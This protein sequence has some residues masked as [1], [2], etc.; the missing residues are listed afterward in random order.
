ML[1]V[2]RPPVPVVADDG[3][4]RLTA[5]GDGYYRLV[6]AF[7]YMEEPRLPPVLNQA[8]RSAGIPLDSTD[9]TFYAGYETIVVENETNINRIPEAIFSYLNRN[10]LHD[11][12]HYGVPIDQ[13]VEIGSQIRV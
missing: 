9:T 12:Q 4:W 10:A 13:V 7:G 11:E 1:T 5:L 3:R 8:A 2:A 6:V